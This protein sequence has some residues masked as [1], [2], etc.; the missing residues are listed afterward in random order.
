[1][2]N[3]FCFNHGNKKAKSTRKHTSMP[4]SSSA[5]VLSQNEASLA[6]A[7]QRLVAADKL[8]DQKAGEFSRLRR[9]MEAA[10]KDMAKGGIIIDKEPRLLTRLSDTIKCAADDDM[11]EW[12]AALEKRSRAHEEF[13][14][15]EE[16]VQNEKKS[17]S[18]D[19][20]VE[21]SIDHAP[22]KKAKTDL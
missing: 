12:C 1:L 3:S 7:K 18:G 10:A 15:A 5:G 13:L 11:E 19:D 16:A 8:L 17:A 22:K 6:V 2:F 21:T 9:A 14:R 4:S 20:E